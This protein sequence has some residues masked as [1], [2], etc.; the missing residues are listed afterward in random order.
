[1]VYLYWKTNW[2]LWLFFMFKIDDEQAINLFLVGLQDFVLTMLVVEKNFQNHLECGNFQAWTSMQLDMSYGRVVTLVGLHCFKLCGKHFSMYFIFRI[3]SSFLCKL[4]RVMFHV[5]L[6]SLIICFSTISVSGIISFHF[7]R[8]VY[9]KL[10]NRL[11]IS[12]FFAC[13]TWF[14]QSS[15]V[16]SQANLCFAFQLQ[17]RLLEAMQPKYDTMTKAETARNKHG[18][19]T[20][21]VYDEER[22]EPYL[23]RLPGIFPDITVNHARYG[24]IVNTCR[25][26]WGTTRAILVSSPRH[27][28][29]SSKRLKHASFLAFIGD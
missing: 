6:F 21:F 4:I 27:I 5:N 25:V 13:Y 16:R 8:S 22:Q 14:S 20:V 28:Y 1:M 9:P 29:Q 26:W 11:T 3:E 10:G 2:P 17:E 19:S 12:T 23:S 24:T 7:G 18:P 15:R